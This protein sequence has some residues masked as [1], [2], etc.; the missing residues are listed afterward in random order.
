[1][2]DIVGQ[3]P[4]NSPLRSKAQAMT[5]GM[6]FNS[7]EHPPKS[8]LGEKHQYRTADGSHHNFMLPEFGKA[9][10]PY[11]KTVRSA[12]KLHGAKPDPGVLFDLLQARDEFHPNE[13]GISSMFL[14][15]A[16]ILIHDL[17]NTNRQDS[18]ISDTSSYLD[19][20]PLYGSSQEDQDKVRLGKDGLLKP[21]TFHEDRLLGQ[22]PGV[23][24]LL[25]MYSRFHNYVA[26]MLKEI[27]ED[28]RFT[29]R[30]NTRSED[31]EAKDNKRT[32]RDPKKVVDNDIFQ[33]ARL[34]V[35]GL[36]ISISLGDYLRAIQGVHE[37]DT[38]WTFD[39]RMYIEKTAQGE[40]VPRGMGNQVS[41]EFN[42]LYRFHP[43]VSK[44]DGEWTEDFIV[45]EA[46]KRLGKSEGFKAED[47]TPRE[48]WAMLSSFAQEK[49]N[50]EP[51]KRNLE[52]LE[53]GTDG[54]FPDEGLADIL[55]TSIDDTA[56]ESPRSTDIFCHR[57]LIQVG[58]RRI[59]CQKRAKGNEDH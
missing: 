32:P 16:T 53:R 47:L 15:H 51:C 48:M 57:V 43:A 9:G 34:I 42:L 14:Y 25:V 58:H 29:E 12:K 24:V 27:N 21:D 55:K 31:L 33:T 1:M 18:N 37:K 4:Y 59:W 26:T 11:A 46:I 20:A 39:P 56:G 54:R 41:A 19:L 44:K 5:V 23:N 7:L 36:Y 50:I 10:M 49:R 6:L 30:P 17:F 13:A 45:K 52:D 3:L 35:G 8:Y 28:G 22:P 40:A 2:M 38:T